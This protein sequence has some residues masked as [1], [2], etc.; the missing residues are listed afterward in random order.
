MDIAAQK[1]I[2]L[3]RREELVGH[4]VDVEHTL[5]ETPSQ[6]WEDRSTER[7]GDEVLEVLGQ[8]ELAELRQIDSALDR[9]KAGVYGDCQKCGEIIA[10]ERLKLLPATPL[11][12]HCAR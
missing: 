2:L 10:S 5:D 1:K 4:L 6:D 12:R 7:Q 3:D 8:A 11:C 9:V